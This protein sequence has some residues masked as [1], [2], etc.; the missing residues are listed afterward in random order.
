M[1]VVEEHN[2]LSRGRY[3]V[4]MICPLMYGS[5]RLGRVVLVQL[6]LMLLKDL[7]P[8]TPQR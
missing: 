8:P 3:R 2:P 5:V 4:V 6:G 7:S 1:F